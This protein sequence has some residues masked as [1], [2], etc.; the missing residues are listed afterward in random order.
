MFLNNTNQIWSETAAGL[1]PHYSLILERGLLFKTQALTALAYHEA[2]Q[3]IQDEESLF[4]TQLR[5]GRRIDGA[6]NVPLEI[7]IQQG[8]TSEAEKDEGLNTDK[9]TN[10]NSCS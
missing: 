5:R 7:H 8:V 4:L 10:K 3:W 2:F 6:T 9:D 1:N